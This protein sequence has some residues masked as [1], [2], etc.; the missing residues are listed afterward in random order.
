MLQ[1][2]HLAT[3]SE[4]SLF[5]MRQKS[6]CVHL[7]TPAVQSTTRIYGR[8]RAYADSSTSIRTRAIKRESATPTAWIR[9]YTGTVYE[10]L[11]TARALKQYPR[12][13]YNRLEKLSTLGSYTRHLLSSLGSSLQSAGSHNRL[14]SEG[15]VSS[16]DFYGIIFGSRP[17]NINFHILYNILLTIQCCSLDCMASCNSLLMLTFRLALFML[18]TRDCVWK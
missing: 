7:T 13:M 5:T 4:W 12:Y 3:C 15:Y 17:C 6:R 8:Q 16:R 10:S 9:S 2:L 14:C 11:L 18:R 1:K